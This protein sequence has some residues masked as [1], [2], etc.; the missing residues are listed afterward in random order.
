MI[1][2]ANKW[3]VISLHCMPC[4]RQL[5]KQLKMNL[6]SCQACATAATQ[7][8]ITLTTHGR[9][10]TACQLVAQRPTLRMTITGR[11]TCVNTPAAATQY[12]PFLTCLLPCNALASA[13]RRGHQVCGVAPKHAAAKHMLKPTQKLLNQAAEFAWCVPIATTQPTAL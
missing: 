13:G 2:A 12:N 5:S 4:C 11:S 6:Q 1:A 9:S 7:L 3:R 8:K 10:M